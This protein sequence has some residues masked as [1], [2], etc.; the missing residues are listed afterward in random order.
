MFL[1]KTKKQKHSREQSRDVTNKNNNNTNKNSL[2]SDWRKMTGSLLFPWQGNSN[3]YRD[4][5]FS[6]EPF[7]FTLLQWS[8]N[9]PSNSLSESVS[10]LLLLL[11]HLP[12][13]SPQNVL[14]WDS[15]FLSSPLPFLL[16]QLLLPSQSG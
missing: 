8:C 6:V 1:G 10:R 11:L 4:H 12:Q 14:L 13:I 2:V 9:L 5:M 3:C 15:A 7:T 16:S